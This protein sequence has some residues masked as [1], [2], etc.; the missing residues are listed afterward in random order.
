MK[1]INFNRKGCK[2]LEG[3]IIAIEET[4]QSTDMFWKAAT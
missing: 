4:A 3:G 1:T 2:C